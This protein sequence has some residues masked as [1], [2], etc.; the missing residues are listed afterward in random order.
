MPLNNSHGQGN[1]TRFINGVTNVAADRTCG[2]LCI[3]DPTS[4]YTCVDD[5]LGGLDVTTNYTLTKTQAGA[6][7]AL[8]TGYEG[9]A[10]VL[11]NTHTS[12]TD[13]CQI[14]SQS[15]GFYTTSG[16][17]RNSATA[18]YF[19]PAL[20]FK[21]K[22][23][24]SS[25]ADSKIYVGLEATSADGTAPTDGMYFSATAG[26]LKF[27][28]TKASTTTTSGTLATLVAATDIVLGFSYHPAGNPKAPGGIV[29]I[30]VNDAIV[31]TAS[32]NTKSSMVITN[33]P[34]TTTALAPIVGTKQTA[35]T[36]NRT[37]TVDY[38]LACKN[39]I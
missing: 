2:L 39:R 4:A 30:Y 15:V 8:S 11:T 19:K 38:I 26:A 9:G 34:A 10:V 7:A 36:A 13:L 25:I 28:L 3:P 37:L 16:L 18:Q 17:V 22:L 14:Q 23:Q 21:T 6:S 31:A 27:N 1:T 24:V 5:F 33:L 29:N 20:V 12:N 32:A 35:T